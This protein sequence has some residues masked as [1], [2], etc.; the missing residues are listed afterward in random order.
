QRMRE[1]SV[2]ASNDT[3]T[4]TDRGAIASELTSLTSEIDRIASTTQFNTKN[5]LNGSLSTTLAGTAASDL[6][7]GEILASSGIVAASVNVTGAAQNTTYTLAA[8]NSTALSLT[9][10][11]GGTTISQTIVLTDMTASGSNSQT[12]NFNTL[13]VSI[14]L[15]GFGANGT[16][17][18]IVT[19]LASTANDTILTSSG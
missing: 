12:L 10:T 19:D 2:Q 5:L 13:G 6:V 11:V 4:N 3:L 8:A 15:Q 16:A 17:A 7:N 9:A 1:L 14:S 18:K